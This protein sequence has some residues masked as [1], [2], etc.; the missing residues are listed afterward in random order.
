MARAMRCA[1]RF[2]DA[3]IHYAVCAGSYINMCWSL[4]LSGM[5]C[6][7]RAS[8]LMVDRFQ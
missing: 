1:V 7:T 8:I 5:R 6:A 2:V 3:A 4:M